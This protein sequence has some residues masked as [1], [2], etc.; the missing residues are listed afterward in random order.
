MTTADCAGDPVSTAVG[1][2]PIRRTIRACRRFR[3]RGART[4]ILRSWRT[5]PASADSLS[6]SHEHG[7]YDGF[8]EVDVTAIVRIATV[9]SLQE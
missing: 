8:R 1:I 4:F 2:E 6:M 9:R 3:R 5:K 7:G